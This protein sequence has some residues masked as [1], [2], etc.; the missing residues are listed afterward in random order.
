MEQ[1][2]YDSEAEALAAA[3][4]D[5]VE[6]ADAEYPRILK[7]LK[8]GRTLDFIDRILLRMAGKGRV[9]RPARQRKPRR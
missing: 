8:G 6:I 7:E 1:Q 2:E 9:R 3:E 4:K 5:T